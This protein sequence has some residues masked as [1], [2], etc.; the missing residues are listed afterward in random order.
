MFQSSVQNFA[1]TPRNLTEN[2]DWEINFMRQVPTTWDETRFLDGYPGKYVALARRS[3]MRWY[4]TVL[5]GQKNTELKT[6]L[7]LSF[8]AGQTVTLLSDGKDGKSPSTQTV[9]LDKKGQ[10]K[11]SLAAESGLVVY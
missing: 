8:L 5:N 11:V 7:D 10:L 1:L 9:K 3:G 6:T 4:V 2:P